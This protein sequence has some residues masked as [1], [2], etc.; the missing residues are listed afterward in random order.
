MMSFICR[1]T[2]HGHRHVEEHTFDRC[3]CFDASCSVSFAI[4]GIARGCRRQLLRCR[5]TTPKLCDP[6]NILHACTPDGAKRNP[7]LG[8][9][10]RWRQFPDRGLQARG[11]GRGDQLGRL[12]LRCH[13]AALSRRG[14]PLQVV[15]D[16]RI[17]GRFLL[18]QAL[19]VCRT[20]ISTEARA[21]APCSP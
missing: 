18:S 3:F 17:V 15:G 7:G 14:P 6:I 1:P 12:G 5:L 21:L 10:K 20:M 11:T 4:A 2:G 13:A 16:D 9:P 19:A 8:L